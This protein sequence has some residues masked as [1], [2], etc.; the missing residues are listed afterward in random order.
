MFEL[1][2]LNFIFKYFEF[3]ISI[4]FEKALRAITACFLNYFVK[5]P[6]DADQVKFLLLF[7]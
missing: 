3:Y 7:L 6:K 2:I 1:S 4:L 5:K